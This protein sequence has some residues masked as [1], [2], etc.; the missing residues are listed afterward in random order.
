[1]VA[2]YTGV[3]VGI[4]ICYGIGKYALEQSRSRRKTVAVQIDGRNCLTSL[5]Q[6][7]F[8][9][10]PPSMKYANRKDRTLLALYIAIAS[11]KCD[12]VQHRGSRGLGHHISSKPARRL[13]FWSNVSVRVHPACPPSSAISASA[14]DPRPC[15]RATIAVK[16]SCSFWIARTS[17]CSSRS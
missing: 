8:P 16:T 6:Q 7:L 10:V 5:L 2:I 1:M 3:L 15:F 12:A 4:V 13:A 11:N 17:T 14:N 9:G